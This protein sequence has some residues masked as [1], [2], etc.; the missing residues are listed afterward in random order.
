MYIEHTGLEDNLHQILT[1]REPTSSSPNAAAAASALLARVRREA[2]SSQVSRSTEEQQK[3]SKEW[4]RRPE[5]K[6]VPVETFSALDVLKHRPKETLNGTVENPTTKKDQEEADEEEQFEILHVEDIDQEEIEVTN[7]KTA[8][9]EEE[10]NNKKPEG[11]TTTHFV[12]D[13]NKNAGLQEKANEKDDEEEFEYIVTRVPKKKSFHQSQQQV[14]VEDHKNNSS[15]VRAIPY[16]KHIWTYRNANLL[17][18]IYSFWELYV[19]IFVW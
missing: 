10:K 16:E 11:A 7:L 12:I 18:Q 2:A 19:L 8:S 13:L 9:V 6:L 15:Q 4:V 3:C 1:N 14:D 5:P 17:S